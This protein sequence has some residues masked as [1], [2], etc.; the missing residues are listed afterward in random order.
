MV[1]LVNVMRIMLVF[2]IVSIF[3]PP[4]RM[5]VMVIGMMSA[6]PWMKRLCLFR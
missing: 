5:S 6:H 3:V 1:G 4:L 2:V